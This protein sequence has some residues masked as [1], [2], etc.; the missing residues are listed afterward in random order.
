MRGYEVIWTWCISY[1][2]SHSMD[3][4]IS[5]PYPESWGAGVS[6]SVEKVAVKEFV[7]GKEGLSLI[8]MTVPLILPKKVALVVGKR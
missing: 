7:Y 3:T 5:T 2:V 1:G 4:E 8:S 6:G